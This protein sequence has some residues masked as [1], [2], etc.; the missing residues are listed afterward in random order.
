MYITKEDI[1]NVNDLYQN[2]YFVI[3]QANSYACGILLYTYKLIQDT[4]G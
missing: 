4:G 3:I 2:A 1:F